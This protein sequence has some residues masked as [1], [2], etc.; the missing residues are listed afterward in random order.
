MQPCYGWFVAALMACGATLAT[1][2][3]VV[4]VQ[5]AGVP[6]GDVDVVAWDN[7]GRLAASRSDGL[8]IARLVL[9]RSV[10]AGAF[11][12]IRRMGF[13]P[14]RV[15]FTG[16]DSL[17][18]TL[19]EVP[20]SLPVLSVE[21]TAL[22]C[23][24]NGDTTADSVWRATASHYTAGLGRLYFQWSGGQVQ[25]T[26]TAD[27]RGYG[28][29]S[30][31]RLVY[32]GRYPTAAV[33]AGA[34]IDGSFPY[35]WFE[36]HISLLGEY[37]RWRYRP[38]ETFDAEHFLT[39]AFQARHA[40]MVLGRSGDA[41]VIGFCARD[42]DQAE[43]EGELQI[44]SDMFLRSAR[45]FYRLPHDNEDAGADATFGVADFEGASYLVAVRGASWRR[46]GRNLYNQERYENF[47]WRVGHTLLESHI[48]RAP[49]GPLRPSPE[50]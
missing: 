35:A 42:R 33:P 4:R 8:G 50:R 9:A 23:P 1:A 22:R 12:L 37:W 38:L 29:G 41:I 49:V 46:A 40:M 25:E 2:Q 3:T 13:A 20:T 27:Q 19:T 18:I 32:G 24:S 36:Q 21:T 31:L 7:D 5:A 44:G 45:W 14:A 15:T 10:G 39:P 34:A 30:A 11:L 43:I 6:L 16:S 26:V 17:T 28:D 47:Q 48:V